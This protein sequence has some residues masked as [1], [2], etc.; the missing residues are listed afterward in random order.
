MG[1]VT[2]YYLDSA[3]TELEEKS[4]RADGFF[5]KIG[6]KDG[7][8]TALFMEYDNGDV[9]E[10]VGERDQYH[11]DEV[12]VRDTRAFENF[13]TSLSPNSSVIYDVEVDGRTITVSEDDML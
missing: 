3:L 11:G 1:L 2:E 8:E 12:V 4:R 9:A 13:F 5:E 7:L 6:L 10:Y